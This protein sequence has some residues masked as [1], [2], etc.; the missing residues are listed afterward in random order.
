LVEQAGRVLD[1]LDPFAL[2]AFKRGRIGDAAR[3]LGRADMRYAM[4]NYRREPVEP[5]GRKRDQGWGE[6]FF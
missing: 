2:L 5:A 6:R 1:L 3:M 4:G